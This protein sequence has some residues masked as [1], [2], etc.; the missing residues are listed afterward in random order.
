MDH[1]PAEEA[2]AMPVTNSNIAATS[3]TSVAKR[4]RM[5]AD[6][7]SRRSKNLDRWKRWKP[8]VSHPRLDRDVTLRSVFAQRMF[9][10]TFYRAQV[11]VYGVSVMLPIICSP[12]QCHKFDQNL[13]KLLKDVHDKLANE[14]ARL[15]KVKTDNGVRGAITYTAPYA[16]TVG[17]YTPEAG[18]FLALLVQFD[19]LAA[20]AD[21]LWM[22]VQWTKDQR[23]Q[24]I[25]TW[26]NVL[27]RL[28]RE[29]NQLQV[30][31]KGAIR[32]H[33]EM[34]S[35]NEA[36]RLASLSDPAVM[37]STPE[38]PTGEEDLGVDKVAAAVAAAGDATPAR[39]GA[40]IADI[41]VLGDIASAVAVPGAA[42][43]RSSRKT[44]ASADLSA[45]VG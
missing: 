13:H 39:D 31:A 18:M 35:R 28:A 38:T 37:D 21:E 14:V 6:P 20:L 24:C 32:R 9:T 42:K 8:S 3:S 26:R 33:R 1:V 17:L 44:A 5:P 27:L 19:R 16:D 25:F 10:M 45:A 36:K 29:M 34:V 2:T 4:R 43:K 7:A 11:A 30:R 23:S 40:P 41:S 12:E 15:E 22:C